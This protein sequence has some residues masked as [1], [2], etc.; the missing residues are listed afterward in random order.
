MGKHATAPLSRRL[1]LARL[2]SPAWNAFDEWLR[3]MSERT[4]WAPTRFA[5][6]GDQSKGIKTRFVGFHRPELIDRQLMSTSQE[7]FDRIRECLSV[8]VVVI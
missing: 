3:D 7:V 4:A 5:L 6:I 8:A 2:R 1:R